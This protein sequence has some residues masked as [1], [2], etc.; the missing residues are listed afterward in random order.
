MKLW[1]FSTASFYSDDVR[2]S[3]FPLFSV[4]RTRCRQNHWCSGSLV[5]LSGHLPVSHWDSQLF[6]CH[7]AYP[8]IPMV[9]DA[10][11]CTHSTEHGRAL[12]PRL[13]RPTRIRRRHRVSRPWRRIPVGCPS[14]PWGLTLEHCPRTHISVSE[15]PRYTARESTSLPHM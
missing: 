13:Y 2:S 9:D 6:H 8:A 7:P 3:S 11:L 14:S 12:L 5:C 10:V 1:L 15:V 4:R